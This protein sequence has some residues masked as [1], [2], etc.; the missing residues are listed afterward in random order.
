MQPWKN[1]GRL[2]HPV[3]VE[4]ING[5]Q[6]ESTIGFAVENMDGRCWSPRCFIDNN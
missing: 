4:T 3:A 6:A 2:E 1:T 5:V